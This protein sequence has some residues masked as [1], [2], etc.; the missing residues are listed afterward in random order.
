MPRKL[1][2]SVSGGVDSMA[3]VGLM[4]GWAKSKN[5]DLK[6]FIVDHKLRS[7]SSDEARSVSSYIES[8]FQI[9]SSI[10]TLS[11]VDKSS[12]K[13]EELARDGRRLLLSQACRRENFDHLLLGHHMNDQI[14][15]FILRLLSGSSWWGLAGMLPVS[16]FNMSYCAKN[17]PL[18]LVR[19]FLNIP[20]SQLIEWCTSQQVKWW[21]DPTNSDIELT[22]RNLIRR[23]YE[24]GNVPSEFSTS[25]VAKLLS[26]FG[27]QRQEACNI[28][29]SVLKQAKITRNFSLES[30]RK[31]SVLKITKEMRELPSAVLD[32]ILFRIISP[33]SPK[34]DETILKKRSTIRHLTQLFKES[35]LSVSHNVLGVMVTGNEQSWTFRR[36]PLRATDYSH[37]EIFRATE[38]WSDFA[39]IDH[40]WYFRWRLK[41]G[42]KQHHQFFSISFLREPAKMVKILA[43]MFNRNAY[44]QVKTY[45]PTNPFFMWSDPADPY[46]ITP[47]KII[48]F[49]TLG[50]ASPD[51]EFEIQPKNALSNLIYVH[52]Y[53]YPPL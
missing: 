30:Q 38:E 37:W 31:T 1:A 48:G 24:I 14:E 35:S 15:L 10:L 45:I 5:I 51:L 52:I 44:E 49:P 47:Q 50:L 36:E 26:L 3:L 18:K 53:A 11:G 9:P 40:R 27:S 29:D 33:L 4:T 25:N 7:E 39:L 41:P 19:P 6:A 12:P 22:D 21:E 32:E 28:A 2:L 34:S 42:K 8:K 17:Y 23:F 20:K 46:T 13:L 43:T 16:P